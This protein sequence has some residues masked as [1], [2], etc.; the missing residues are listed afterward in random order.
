MARVAFCIKDTNRTGMRVEF[1][2]R[3]IAAVYQTFIIEHSAFAH[4]MSRNSRCLPEGPRL[5]CQGLT[6]KFLTALRTSKF[7]STSLHA[8]AK[9]SEQRRFM[10]QLGP[11]IRVRS[12]ATYAMNAR[13]HVPARI[14]PIILPT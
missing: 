5:E 9:H 8:E 10:M 13:L 2:I 11:S 7:S 6:R 1:I 12:L 14:C 4:N 3:S